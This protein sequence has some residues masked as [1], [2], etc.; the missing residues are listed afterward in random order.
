M[1]KLKKMRQ[2][3]GREKLN[4][5]KRKIVAYLLVIT[6]VVTLLPMWSGNSERVLGS[7][8]A[9]YQLKTESMTEPLAVDDKN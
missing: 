9:I 8:N 6:L 4:I 1:L 5:K 2:M 3:K 7:E